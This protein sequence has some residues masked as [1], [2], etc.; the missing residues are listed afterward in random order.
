MLDAVGIRLAEQEPDDGCSC[1]GAR[2][3]RRLHILYL[4]ILHCEPQGH[5]LEVAHMRPRG[6]LRVLVRERVDVM[7]KG[8]AAAAVMAKAYAAL[9]P[10]PRV[11][12]LLNNH[13]GKGT[14]QAQYQREIGPIL[15][16]ARAR[17]TFQQTRYAGHGVDIGRELNEDRFDIVACC[18]GDGIP[19]EVINGM[20][21]RP[22]RGAAVFGKVAVA[23][24]PCGLG[25]AM[26]RSNFHCT[27]AATATLRM[28][29]LPRVQMDLMAV[30]SGSGGAQQ[31]RL[32]FLL[33]LYGIVADADIGTE[34]LRWMGL[35]RFDL[36]VARRLLTKTEYPCDL[37]V[38]FVA[39]DNDAVK[40]HYAQHRGA[41]RPHTPPKGAFALAAPPLN[42]PVPSTWLQMRATQRLNMFYVGKMPFVLATAQMFPAALP[43][44][45]AMDMVITDTDMGRLH[46]GT[47]GFAV[48]RGVHVGDPQVRHAKVLAYRLVPRVDPTD[49]YI[50]V[51]GE[52]IPFEPFQVEVLPRVM[53]TL[54]HE[55]KYAETAYE[56][57]L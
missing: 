38:Q 10:Q 6:L 55:G 32:L 41:Q 45:G 16:A 15:E 5:A 2:P 36:G 33:Q 34:H 37:W 28:L 54:L 24:I 51:D 30:T 46:S 25:N 27:D 52:E 11:L 4:D 20:Y 44:D 14:A 29:K 12:V 1:L 17:V 13:G 21:Q 43:G 42:E 47:I 3:R 53:T 22:D 9:E 49:H 35:V 57:S 18:L 23:Q 26:L 7:G 40:M 56:K 48:D 19:H 39:E 31:T 8:D 50:L